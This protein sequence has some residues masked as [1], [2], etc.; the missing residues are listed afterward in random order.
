MSATDAVVCGLAPDALDIASGIELALAA[1]RNGDVATVEAQA[2][3][4]AELGA[5][6]DVMTR[7]LDTEAQPALRDLI[8]IG[9][10]AAQE[11][12][13]LAAEPTPD[14]PDLAGL[15]EG[16]QATRDALARMRIELELIG[17][18]HCWSD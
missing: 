2:D 16:L 4:L 5:K 6:I 9:L 17:L 7:G 13:F 18:D 1:A 15:E 12:A 11:G 3:T 14:R 8:I 10:F